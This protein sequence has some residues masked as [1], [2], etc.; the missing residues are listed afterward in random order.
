MV[1]VAR[2]DY[3]ETAAAYRRAR[4][5]PVEAVA[6][7][8]TAVRALALPPARLVA[9]V[10]AGPGGFLAPLAA[11]F[12]APV[13]AVEPSPAMRTEASESDLASTFPYV[14]AAAERLPIRDGTVDVAWLSTVIHQFDDL[15]AAVAE[16]RRVVAPA[17]HVL[18]RGFFADQP[19]TGVLARFPGIDRAAARFPATHDVVTRLERAGFASSTVVDVTE[20][21]RFEL[22]AWTDRVRSIRHTDSAL[23]PLTDDEFEAGVAAVQAQHGPSAEPLVSD[24]VLRLV[25]LGS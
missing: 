23:R 19:M 14:A 5:L 8:T 22:E 25:V 21:W 15:D 24:M 9:D 7:W 17:G 16:L 3:D 13:V 20:R 1:R 4:N 6:A 10:G 18:V 12:G 2:V 11:W